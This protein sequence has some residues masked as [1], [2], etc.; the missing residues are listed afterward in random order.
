MSRKQRKRL[1]RRRHLDVTVARAIRNAEICEQLADGLDKEE[2]GSRYDLRPN[3]IGW[4]WEEN[5]TDEQYARRLRLIRLD[6]D[7]VAET[8]AQLIADI[9]DV[10]RL[11]REAPTR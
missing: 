2:I 9:D 11:T 10:R 6:N 4:I 1:P 5:A 8:V 3:T 7:S